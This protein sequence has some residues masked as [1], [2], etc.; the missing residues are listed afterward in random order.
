SSGLWCVFDSMRPRLQHRQQYIDLCHQKVAGITQEQRIR[1][2]NYIGRSQTV[3]NETRRFTDCFRQ[4]RGEGDDI[5]VGSFLDLMDARDRELRFV[6]NP[7]ECRAREC[8]HLSV[9]FADGDLYVQPFLK[10]CLFRPERAHFGKCVAGNH[11]VG[12]PE[13]LSRTITSSR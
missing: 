11:W 1:G 12:Q 6:L 9:Y 4:I 10:L 2:I 8:S 7:F 5:M 13:S 3:M